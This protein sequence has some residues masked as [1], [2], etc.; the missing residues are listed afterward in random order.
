MS[1][2]GEPNEKPQIYGDPEEIPEGPFQEN[3]DFDTTEDM[4]CGERFDFES[5]PCCGEKVYWVGGNFHGQ[6]VRPECDNCNWIGE[7]V[8]D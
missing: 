7:Y 4:D 6:P 3:G 2:E 5:C 1:Y 8:Y